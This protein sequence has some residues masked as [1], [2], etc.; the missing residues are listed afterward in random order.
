MRKLVHVY[1]TSDLI[2][3]KMRRKKGKLKQEVLP[4]PSFCL[5][6]ATSGFS[7]WFLQGGEGGGGGN[8]FFT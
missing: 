5:S 2:E 8:Y 4:R 6:A 1:A 3:N 7:Q